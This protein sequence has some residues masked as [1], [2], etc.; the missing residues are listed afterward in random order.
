VSFENKASTPRKIKD[1][2]KE[3]FFGERNVMTFI[4][5]LSIPFGVVI[6]ISKMKRATRC[7]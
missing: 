1:E 2:H 6:N 7:C 3:Q 5:S 4:S